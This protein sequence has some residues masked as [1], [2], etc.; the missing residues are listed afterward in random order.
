[1]SSAV[2]DG[3]GKFFRPAA[4]AAV[5]GYSRKMAAYMPVADRPSQARNWSARRTSSKTVQKLCM[6]QRGTGTPG[7]TV[8]TPRAVCARIAPAARLPRRRS[9]V[10]AQRHPGAG[11]VTDLCAAT[12]E[13]RPPR[14]ARP[15]D[16]DAH[17]GPGVIWPLRSPTG[18]EFRS[19]SLQSSPCRCTAFTNRNASIS[20]GSSQLVRLRETPS[21]GS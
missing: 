5:L 10:Q 1:M 16:P 12:N 8:G 17:R 13:R 11:H 20:S 4:R 14:C 15:F 7:S 18:Q 19:L 2:A 3:L 9:C 21:S 6:S